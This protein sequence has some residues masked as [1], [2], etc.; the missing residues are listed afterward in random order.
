MRENKL[1]ANLKECV[2][3]L[4]KSSVLG[5]Y[6]RK[7]GVLADPQKISS[8]CSWPTSKNPLS[9]VNG[10]DWQITCMSIRKIVLRI[11]GPKG[12]EYLIAQGEEEGN[13]RIHMLR[14]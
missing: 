7:L 5:C 2:S 10:S 12:V 11:L 14:I 6:V 4:W 1:H 13:K 9:C 8:I 3:A